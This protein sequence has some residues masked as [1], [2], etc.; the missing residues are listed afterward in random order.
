PPDAPDAVKADPPVLTVKLIGRANFEGK[1][2]V[3]I[4]AEQ[5]EYQLLSLTA[6]N[7]DDND[8]SEKNLLN[9][10]IKLTT[11]ARQYVEV[12]TGRPLWIEVTRRVVEPAAL[13]NERPVNRSRAVVVSSATPGSP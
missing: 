2:A 12:E 4:E 9:Q 1:E 7:A 6:G 11:F 5:L 10:V 13:K 3:L 8:P